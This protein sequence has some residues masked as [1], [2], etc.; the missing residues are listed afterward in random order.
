M[1][2]GKDGDATLGHLDDE[3]IAEVVGGARYKALRA[4]HRDG[5]FADISYCADCDQLYDFPDALV[6][7]NIPGRAYGQS[8]IVGGLD[9]R[10]YAS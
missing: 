9:H 7:S 3:S 5:R 8:K 2:L 1:V 10:T 6:W 4:A